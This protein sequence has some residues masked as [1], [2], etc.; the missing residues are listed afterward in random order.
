MV[1][2]NHWHGLRQYDAE[3]ALPDEDYLVV[4]GQLAKARYVFEESD[5][6]FDRRQKL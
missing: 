6:S 3:R 5:D 4:D 2:V 1:W